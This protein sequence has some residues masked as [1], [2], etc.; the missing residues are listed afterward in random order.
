[1][2]HDEINQKNLDYLN[3]ELSNYKHEILLTNG[4]TLY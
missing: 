3:D 4:N 2:F 1:M